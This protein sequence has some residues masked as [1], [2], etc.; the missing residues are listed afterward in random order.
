MKKI[1]LQLFF[2]HLIVTVNAQQKEI[3]SLETL[4]ARHTV[5]DTVR[6]QLL[7]KLAFNYA[8]YDPD[9]GLI[10]A[11]EALQLA[12]QLKDTVRTGQALTTQGL[13]YHSLGN[14]SL[15][16][17]CYESALQLFKKVNNKKG[18]ASVYN[19]M[20][21]VWFYKS[22]YNQAM[23][24]RKKALKIFEELHD[25][26]R[27]ATMYCNIS[28]DYQYLSDYAQSVN[29]LFQ[30]L[31]LY[32]SIGNKK[33]IANTYKNLGIQYRKLS[34]LP[35][36]LAY[37]NKA[38][39]FFRQT[40]QTIS[41][42]EQL[43]NIANVYDDMSSTT[44]ALQYY[45]EALTLN[46]SINNKR[47]IAS[48]FINMGMVYSQIKEYDTAFICIEKSIPLFEESG[49]KNSLAIALNKKGVL[50][51]EAPD[52]ILIKQGIAP[53]Q[54]YHKSI[55]SLNRGIQLAVEIEAIDVQASLLASLSGVYE[56]KKDFAKA[57]EAY[58]K[59]TLLQDSILNDATAEKITQD[60][61][62]YE[63]D[64]KEAATKAENEKKVAL[65]TEEIKRERVIKN[66]SIFG[67]SILLLSA[68]ISFVF[69]KRRR[70]A[71]A[72]KVETDFKL[73]VSDTEMKALRSQ[74]NPH[75]IF[76]SLNS[77]SDYISRNDI[78]A[79]DNYLAKFAKVMRMILENSD[80]KEVTLADDLKALELYIQLESLRMEHKFSYEI[81]V[82]AGI[83]KDNT[84]VPPLM[85]QP[86]VENSIW[87]G[88]SKKQGGG[89]I[90]IHIRKEGDMINC[91]IEDNGI[92]REKSKQEKS[93]VSNNEKKS[94]GMKITRA[95]IDILNKLK[96]SKA[97][98]ELFDL[99]EGLRVEVKL[100]LQLSF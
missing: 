97:A 70:D 22:D 20:G 61:L 68:F 6:F 12:K 49:D 4:L 10:K 21:I 55:E 48:N 18:I 60:K 84:L 28:L 92:G 76:N 9:K 43:A 11:A 41:V 1:L 94:L 45:H 38:L 82:D 24:N 77:I 40:D 46:Q 37:H 59:F 30:A 99:A 52:G 14:D 83:D 44:T 80:L 79:A 8:D 5:A 47:G 73:Q 42:A 57:L 35:E 23:A 62:Q 51:N 15:T 91:I 65:A 25:T 85:L 7:Y 29:Y 96:K 19:N 90:A 100:P 53:P 13:N 27:I 89:K 93:A 63:F 64:K 50:I 17:A 54:R 39:E 31:K 33:G 36:A 86:F 26:A 95:R 74:M 88:I 78:K 66:S 69:Y 67:G 87:H 34:K 3:D 75:F 72:Q 2:I 81:I 71:V 16:M 58:K 32:E 98:V 56:S